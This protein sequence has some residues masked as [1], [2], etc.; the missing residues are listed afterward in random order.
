MEGTVY[1]LVP[2]LVAIVLCIVMREAIFSLFMG[3][4][5]GALIIYSFSPLTAFYRSVD[6]I[7]LSVFIQSDNAVI[8][9][10][11][12][13]MGGMVEILNQSRVSRDLVERIAARLR[14]RVRANLL[15]WLTGVV[16]FI[17]DYANALIVGNSYRK[18]ADRLKISRAKLAYLVDTTSAPVTSLAFVSTWIGFEISVILKSLKAEGIEGYSGYELFVYSIPYRFYPLLALLFCLYICAMSRDFGPM[19]RAERLARIREPEETEASSKRPAA[20]WDP[21]NY[22]ILLPIAVL[23]IAA[24]ISLAV[25]G[26]QN[27]AVT[28]WVHPW[29]SV[30]ALLSNADP[31]RSILWATMIATLVSFAVHIG[32]FFE[33]FRSVFTSWLEG[34]KGMFTICL[35]LTLAWSIGDVCTRLKT[36]AYVASL[37]GQG[38]D[39]HFLPLLTFLFA[40]AISFATGTSFGTMSILMPVALP[41]A[42]HY[43]VSAHDI[44]YGTIGS[45]LGGAIFGDHCSPLSDTTI[46]SAGAS[47]CSLTD[48]V[49]T[50][51]P[52]ALAVALISAGC[53]ALV[54]IKGISPYSLLLI[55]AVILLGVVFAFG[56]KIPE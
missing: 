6:E 36:G 25:S 28:D 10:F 14:T 8:L 44:L 43:G 4:F 55:G 1:S 32:V 5:V 31:F 18:L 2:P 39:P 27:G 21:W 20:A 54:P 50:Q 29:Q 35:I 13:L 16:F 42:I 11:T 22:A 3:I 9:F 17:D 47:G 12:V 45:V 26:Y 34:C 15:I 48:H 7:I 41:L 33:S 46:L 51:L 30:I 52:Y 56:R 40:A 38:F 49:N 19:K 37:L 24:F 23:L 53:L